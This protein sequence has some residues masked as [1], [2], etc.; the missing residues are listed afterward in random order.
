MVIFL[1]M[2]RLV[3]CL[4]GYAYATKKIPPSLGFSTELSFIT[5]AYA[6]QDEGKGENEDVESDSIWG[7]YS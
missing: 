2:S 3:V 4:S 7:R 1:L 5:N 6:D